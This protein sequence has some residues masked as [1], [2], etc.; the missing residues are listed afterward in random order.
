MEDGTKFDSS[1]D[2]D[3]PFDF[4]LGKGQ[5]IKSWDRAVAQMR[6]GEISLLIARGDYAYG[7][8]GSPPKIPPNAT[9]HFEVELLDFEDKQKETWEMTSEEKLAEGSKLKEQGNEHFKAGEY[10]QAVAKYDKAIGIFDSGAG[11]DDSDEDG[12]EGAQAKEKKGEAAAAAMKQS[13]IA[14]HLN[15]AAAFLKLKKHNKAI[16]HCT[17]ALAAD[18][19]NVK[20][21]YRRGQA[22]AED[23]DFELAKR[24][25]EKVLELDP[26][27]KDAKAAI[28]DIAR[29]QSALDK[30]Q[31]KVF[32]N[33]FDKIDQI[34]QEEAQKRLKQQQ[35][36]QE[37][38]QQ[39]QQQ[40]QQEESKKQEASP[41]EEVKN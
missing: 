19:K 27:N 14:C 16:D 24:D 15:S 2:R 22:H 38:Q 17:K 1:R 25:F 7:A 40:Q 8:A 41:M 31:K 37:Q 3:Q 36:E 20:A 18:P 32:S 9:L 12:E 29:K 28:A 39:Q 6:K 33:L 35:Q 34:E 30:K 4:V 23:S 26:S 10:K 21:L 13:S 5:V 11:M